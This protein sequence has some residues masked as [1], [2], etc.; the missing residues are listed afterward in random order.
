LKEPS[1]RGIKA[2]KTP[3]RQKTKTTNNQNQTY[4]TEQVPN[5]RRDHLRL[6]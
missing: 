2:K 4:N 3:W 1:P 5:K 6:T